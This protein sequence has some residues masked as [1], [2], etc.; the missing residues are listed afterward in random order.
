MGRVYD[1]ADLSSYLRE[2]EGFQTFS[3]D[4]LD[5]NY[6]NTYSGCDDL[7][8][9]PIQDEHIY[10]VIHDGNIAQIENGEPLNVSYFFDQATYDKF[11]NPSTGE[12]DAAALSEA[13][14]LD[15]AGYPNYR[16]SI[17]CFDVNPKGVSGGVLKLP[18][19]VCTAN[20]QFGGGG[21][22]Q[23]FAPKD[24]S[25]DLQ[26]S[27]VLQINCEKSHFHTGVNTAVSSEKQA[28][29]NAG[30]AE[31]QNYCIVNDTP[32]HDTSVTYTTGFESTPD[33]VGGRPF[34]Y[35]L[36]VIESALAEVVDVVVSTVEES[37]PLLHDLTSLQIEASRRYGMTAAETL[38]C[39]QHLYEEG[40][41][42]YPRT[43]SNYISSDMENTVESLF[44][45]TEDNS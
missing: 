37:P 43:S 24:I 45:D 40:D 36:D 19:G 20:T 22:H 31:R 17:A 14:Q 44:S 27:G 39:V 6:L 21:G 29:V 9:S 25:A 34:D 32:H 12:F 2:A 42:T 10:A 8:I 18:T 26:N 4:P 38:A 41:A 23:T 28:I 11:V 16:N 1:P 30:V 13:L 35:A 15:P 3:N 33:L 7:S 5:V